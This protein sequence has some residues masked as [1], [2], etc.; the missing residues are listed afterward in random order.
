MADS[1]VAKSNPFNDVDGLLEALKKAPQDKQGAFRVATWCMVIQELINLK[2]AIGQNSELAQSAAQAA[3]ERPD[4][5]AIKAEIEKDLD[6]KMDSGDA[7]T[8]L[9]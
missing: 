5:A 9:F 2:Q 7:E 8:I 3:S 6:K 1:N 4:I